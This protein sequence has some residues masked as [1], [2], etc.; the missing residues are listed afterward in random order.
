MDDTMKGRIEEAR[1]CLIQYRDESGKSQ[2]KIAKEL[3]VSDGVVSAFINGTYKTPHQ[4]VDKVEALLSM[5]EAK[6]I[7]PQAPGFVMTSVSKRIMDTMEYCHLLGKTGIAY[8]DAGVG[9]TMS[10]MEYKKLHPE[11][12]VITG[13][14]VFSSISGINDLLCEQMGIREKNAKRICMEII[15]RLKGSGR[16]LIV[17]EAQY[18]TKKALEYIK[19]IGDGSGVG[20]CLVGNEEII[21]KVKGTGKSDFAQLFSR[22][23]SRAVLTHDI[24][25]S[26]IELIFKSS[27]LDKE[28]LD[29]L[30]K[31]SQ[32][33]YGVRGAV[34]IYIAAVAFFGKVNRLSAIKVAKEMNIG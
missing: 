1:K 31:I 23:F 21:S 17:D 16:L 30:Y 19:C 12:I 6:G 11:S 26:D 10:I 13:N 34:N 24:K 27:G 9:K 18:L 20:I 7:A 14:P 4:I 25:E 22:V 5:Q 8:G 28:T 29:F 32:T 33:K 15:S 3:G 2:S